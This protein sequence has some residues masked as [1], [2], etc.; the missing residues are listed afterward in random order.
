MD[1]WNMSNMKNPLESIVKCS[2]GWSVVGHNRKILRLTLY[3]SYTLDSGKEIKEKF[4]EDYR[5]LSIH[6]DCCIPFLLNK[7]IELKD[8]ILQYTLCETVT[9]S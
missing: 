7:R 3:G 9:C 1:E 8:L 5:L 2:P 6:I 4:Q